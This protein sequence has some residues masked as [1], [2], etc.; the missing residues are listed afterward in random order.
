MLNKLCRHPRYTGP[1]TPGVR[2]GG[3]LPTI[4]PH[5]TLNELLKLGECIEGSTDDGSDNEDEHN[6]EMFN[7]L[8]DFIATMHV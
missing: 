3:P 4:R 8:T 2:P 7:A 1:T 6:E 5:F